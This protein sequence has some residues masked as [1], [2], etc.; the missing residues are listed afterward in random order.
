MQMAGETAFEKTAS[1]SSSMLS[2]PL[3]SMRLAELGLARCI[4]RNRRETEADHQRDVQQGTCS[5]RVS[6]HS[7]EDKKDGT[8]SCVVPQAEASSRG[9]FMLYSSHDKG[10]G[11]GNSRS[12]AE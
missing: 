3:I 11:Q 2:Y 10:S 8:S 6:G 12:G 5:R 1:I 9:A 4:S 7:S